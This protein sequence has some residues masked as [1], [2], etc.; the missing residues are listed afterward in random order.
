MLRWHDDLVQV[1]LQQLGNHVTDMDWLRKSLFGDIN[2]ENKEA[3]K[4]IKAEVEN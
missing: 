4:E 3:L 1:A 2:G